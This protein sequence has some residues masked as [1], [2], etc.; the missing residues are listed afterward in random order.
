MKYATLFF[1]L[2]S[3]LL[4]AQG[5]VAPQFLIPGAGITTWT[6]NSVFTG[7]GT[8][9]PK[10]MA[11][12]TGLGITG[13]GT[14]LVLANTAVTAGVYGNTTVVPTIT[15]DAQGRITAAS[16]STI[17]AGGGSG[18][19][20][21]FSGVA[22]KIPVY[23][24]A[25]ALTASGANISGNVISAT[26]FSGS[27]ASLTGIPSLTATNTYSSAQYYG[28]NG[29]IDAAGN[30]A[31]ANLVV[32][33]GASISGGT[34]TINAGIIDSSA[35]MQFADARLTGANGLYIDALAA[36]GPVFANPGDGL[37]NL[38]ISDERAKDKV[39][40]NPSGLWAVLT[41]DTWIYTLKAD[42]AKHLRNGFMAQDVERAGVIGA[43]NTDANGN[44][45]IADY[46]AFLSWHHTAIKSLAWLTGILFAVVFALFFALFQRK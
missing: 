23:S 31:W 46:M 8:G 10:Q 27:G 17:S 34:V 45:T 18:N 32:T 33:G 4:C 7:N 14:T 26:G 20:T 21:S 5:Q 42:D 25:L 35:N 30:S 3:S 38:V 1:C 16:N 40:R 29:I 28:A 41:T 12:G 9:T 19:V 44:K 36:G 11:I 24:S 43:I 37:L 13:N 2:L 6:N 15:I 22:N 39:R